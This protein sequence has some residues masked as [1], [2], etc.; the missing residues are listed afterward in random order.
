MKS[1]NKKNEY[2][3]LLSALAYGA[4]D[5]SQK[6]VVKYG[7]TKAKDYDELEYKLA[8]IYANTPDKLEIEKEFASIHPHS[9]FILKYLAPKIDKKE[10]IVLKDIQVKDVEST[11]IPEQNSNCCGCPYCKS[12]SAEGD[13]PKTDIKNF[14]SVFILGIIAIVGIVAITNK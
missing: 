5:D 2:K 3:T 12:S 9:K 1:N 4:P 11:N 10:D 13:L 7:E 14:D 6:L 8:K